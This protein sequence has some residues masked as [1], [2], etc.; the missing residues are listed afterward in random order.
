[1][2]ISSRPLPQLCFETKC[3]ELD[4]IALLKFYRARCDCDFKYG[5]WMGLVEYIKITFLFDTISDTL[6]VIIFIVIIIIFVITSTPIGIVIIVVNIFILA[7]MSTR[8]ES[9]WSSRPRSTPLQP[10]L[11][12]LSSSLTWSTISHDIIVIIIQKVKTA[13]SLIILYII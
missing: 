11:P 7:T 10:D 13:C 5:F 4:F 6:T 8:T 1:M 12:A 9:R 3:S 2:T